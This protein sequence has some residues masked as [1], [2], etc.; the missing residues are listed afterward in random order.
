LIEKKFLEFWNIVFVVWWAY[1]IDLDKIDKIIDFKLSIS[2]MTFP[3]NMA[4]LILLEQ[5]YRI[6]NIKK[7]TWYNH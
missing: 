2:E 3:H 7:W 1:W 5:I 4:Y 6:I